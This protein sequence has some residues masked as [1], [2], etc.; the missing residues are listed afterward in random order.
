MKTGK[1]ISIAV[2]ILIFFFSNEVYPIGDIGV[3]I[4]FGITHDPN[5]L[6]DTLNEYNMNML[7]YKTANPDTDVDQ[8]NNPYTPIFGVNFRYN[9]NYLL[10][11]I[12]GTYT[13]ALFPKS[14]GSLKTASG[15]NEITI[16]SSQ[17]SFPG[18]IALIVPLKKRALAYLGGGLNL[19]FCYV[20]VEQTIPGDGYVT[21]DDRLNRYSGMF[22]GF[23]IIAGIEFP[24]TDKYTFTGEWIHQMGS[25]PMIKSKDSTSEISITIDSNIILFGINYYILI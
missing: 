16:E 23:H 1:A 9:F 24:L 22:G 10:F 13:R 2:I 7:A 20:S 11:R 18:S 3:G 5:N 15:E 19:H 17:A 6:D 8:I 21:P 25:S 12:G 4:N 14:D